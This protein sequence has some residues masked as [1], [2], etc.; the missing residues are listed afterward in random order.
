M[1]PNLNK[2]IIKN[3][4]TLLETIIAVFVVIVGIIGIFTIIQNLNTQ[5]S[6]SSNRLIAIYLAQE[7]MEIIRNIR[8]TNWLEQQNDPENTWDEGLI[9]CSTGCE[10]DFF[11]TTVEDPNINNPSGHH[12]L[13]LYSGSLLKIDVN[14]FYN[15]FLGSDTKFKRKITITTEGTDTLKVEVLVSWQERGKNYEF[16]TIEKLYNWYKP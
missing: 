1:L 5:S 16:K 6:Y 3:S 11:C 10:A 14:S 9:G 8:D 4:F 7:G 15:Y 2:K 13:A 12:C